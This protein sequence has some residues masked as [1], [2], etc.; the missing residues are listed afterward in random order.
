[1]P[2]QENQFKLLI[3]NTS[4]VNMSDALETQEFEQ[5]KN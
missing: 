5:V 3:I 4:I 1:M 2:S